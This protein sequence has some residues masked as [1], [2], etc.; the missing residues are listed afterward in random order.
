MF[1]ALDYLGKIRMTRETDIALGLPQNKRIITGM[2]HMATL[3]PALNKGRMAMGLLLLLA[4][5][6]MTA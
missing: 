5:I 4:S 3:T 2:R 1:V 6:L